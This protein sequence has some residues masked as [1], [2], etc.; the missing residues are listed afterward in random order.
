MTPYRQLDS[1]PHVVSSGAH[2]GMTAESSLLHRQAGDGGGRDGDGSS[3]RG[4]DRRAVGSSTGTGE[5]PP[6]T[7]ED[8]EGPVD[9]QSHIIAEVGFSEGDGVG[10]WDKE[11]SAV[12]SLVNNGMSTPDQ[13]FVASPVSGHSIF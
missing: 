4:E 6:E 12:P 8:K 9:A 2:S 7:K 5:S 11:I 10:A 1:T 13:S 3:R